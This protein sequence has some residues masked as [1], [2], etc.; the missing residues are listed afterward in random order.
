MKRSL[1]LLVLAMLLP[2]GHGQVAGSWS[3]KMKRAGWFPHTCRGQLE[4]RKRSTAWN[5]SLRFAK[6]LGGRRHALGQIRVAGTSVRFV[7][8]APPMTLTFS[9][10]LAK[11]RLTG[12]C[13]WDGTGRFPWS[14]ERG[15]STLAAAPRVAK[16]P[17]PHIEGFDAA[18]LAA[19][20]EEARRHHSDALL[21]MKDGTVVLDERFG[22]PAG[23]IEAMSV[24]KSI[25]NLA[26]GHLVQTGKI[27]SIDVPVHTLYPEWKQGKKARITVA[28]LLNHTSGLQ[29]DRHTREIYASP[30]FVQLALCAEL[31]S[32]PGRRFFYNN[33]AVNLLAGVV[34]RA[35]GQH[36]DAYLGRHVFAPLGIR[37]FTWSKD[38]NGNPH[39]MSGLQIRAE[40]LARLGELMRVGG[41]WN[42]LEIVSRD[43]VLRSTRAAQDLEP[44]CGLLWWVIPEWTKPVIDDRCFDAW[45]KGG[46]PKS[47]LDRVRP[48]KD[49]PLARKT[50][51]AA[52]TKAFEGHGGLE[53]WYDNTWRRGLPDGSTVTGPPIGFAAKGYLGQFLVVLP[54]R[55]LVAV[56]QI[57]SGSHQ[58]HADGFGNFIAMVRAL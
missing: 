38:R 12:T 48:L 47:F 26:I 32:D 28:H 52:L 5:G 30:D 3:L 40:D 10:T 29:A 8:A 46:A 22:Q 42:G 23:P 58:G 14:A 9:G 33:K 1:V 13:A 54:G 49:R 45:E 57:R 55:G 17:R 34:H 44:G 31:T 6:V 56:R 11:G 21:L 19:L 36:L 18:A 43:W 50:F 27:D 53:T 25:V 41:T 2:G 24:T 4:L 15:P 35:S 20:V 7:V 51:F 16:T 39:G 37:N